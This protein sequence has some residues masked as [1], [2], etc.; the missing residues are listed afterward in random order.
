[1]NFSR[2]GAH[3]TLR[4]GRHENKE[5]AFAILVLEFFCQSKIQIQLLNIENPKKSQNRLPLLLVLP[6]TFADVSNFP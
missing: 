5:N 6:Q 4:A 3:K 2:F 1:V